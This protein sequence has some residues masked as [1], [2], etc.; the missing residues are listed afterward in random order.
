MQV[1]HFRDVFFVHSEDKE[2]Q[3]ASA[4][5]VADTTDAALP[6]METPPTLWLGGANLLQTPRWLRSNNISVVINCA[7]DTERVS[8]DFKSRASLIAVH[9]LNM[10]DNAAF[11]ARHAMD[12][13]A[14]ALHIALDEGRSVYCHCKSVYFNCLMCRVLGFGYRDKSIFRLSCVATAT[15]LTHLTLYHVPHHAR[16]PLHTARGHVP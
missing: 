14:S 6:P 2:W 1:D 12:A 7:D 9:E 5:L 3:R 8:E 16:P 15:Q 11:P 4:I 13:G 10:Q